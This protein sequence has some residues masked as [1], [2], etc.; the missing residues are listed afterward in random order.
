[1][2][3]FPIVVPSACAT[4]DCATCVDAAVCTECNSGYTL[5][6]S[7]C[8]GKFIVALINLMIIT[9]SI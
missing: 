8:T 4:T 9:K 3:M 6:G 7:T 1:M 5:D 2:K